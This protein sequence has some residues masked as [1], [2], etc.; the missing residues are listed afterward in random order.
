M[1]IIGDALGWIGEL[2]WS[3]ISW[4]GRLIQN[5]IQGLIDFLMILFELIIALVDGLLYLLY[6][7]GMLAVLLFQLIFE[8]AKLLWSF[9]V[10]FVRTLGSLVY[11]PTNTSGTGYSEILGRLFEHAKVLQIDVIAYVLLFV[12][13]F[14]TAIV[15]I[16]LLSSIRVGGE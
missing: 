15:A 7:I 13:W 16:R 8:T 1:G 2:I 4:V 9:V 11:Q 10:G 3:A 14:S 5:V 6:K 12:L